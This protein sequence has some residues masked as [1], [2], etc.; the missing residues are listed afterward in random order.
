MT[1]EKNTIHRVYISFLSGMLLTC[2]CVGCGGQPGKATILRLRAGDKLVSSFQS[3]PASVF[4]IGHI[5][6]LQKDS[7]CFLE[8]LKAETAGELPLRSDSGWDAPAGGITLL[9][10][11]AAVA[12]RERLRGWSIMSLKDGND[13]ALVVWRP[14][15]SAKGV[16]D[17]FWRSEENTLKKGENIFSIDK[18]PE[19]IP[20]DFLGLATVGNIPRCVKDNGSEVSKK[21]YVPGFSKSIDIGKVP[22]DSSGSY[23]FATLSY[24]PILRRSF[25]LPAQTPVPVVFKLSGA[26]VVSRDYMAQFAVL[27]GEV[28][29]PVWADGR[30]YTLKPPESLPDRYGLYILCC[31]LIFSVALFTAARGRMAFL[32]GAA[33]FLLLTS[34]LFQNDISVVFKYCVFYGLFTSLPTLAI[35]SWLDK[36]KSEIPF[37]VMALG[38]YVTWK[39]FLMVTGKL[40]SLF[41]GSLPMYAGTIAMSLIVLAFKQRYVIP[42]FIRKVGSQWEVLSFSSR[43][44]FLSGLGLIL[45]AWSRGGLFQRHDFDSFGYV[46]LITKALSTGSLNSGIVDPFMGPPTAFMAAYILNPLIAF[47]SFSSFVSA[48]DPN[49]ILGFAGLENAFVWCFLAGGISWVIY[50][51]NNFLIA[52]TVLLAAIFQAAN[53]FFEIPYFVHYG[54]PGEAGFILVLCA[55]FFYLAYRSRKANELLLFSAFSLLTGLLCHIQFI[56]FAVM[57]FAISLGLSLVSYGKSRGYSTVEAAHWV[58]WLAIIGATYWLF[59]KEGVKPESFVMGTFYPYYYFNLLGH[60][61]VKPSVLLGLEGVAWVSTL[62]LTLAVL[63]CLW[64]RGKS[65]VASKFLA[66]AA[67]ILSIVYFMPGVP[68]FLVPRI[69][70]I[71]FIRLAFVWYALFSFFALAFAAFLADLFLRKTSVRISKV[72]MLLAGILFFCGSALGYVDISLLEERDYLKI[73]KIHELPVVQYLRTQHP[74]DLLICETTRA[75]WLGAQLPGYVY[76]IMPSRSRT[77]FPQAEIRFAENETIWKHLDSP[78]KIAERVKTLSPAV[79]LL[80]VDDDSIEKFYDDKYFKI[81]YFD[82]RWAIFGLR[83]YSGRPSAKNHGKLFGFGCEGMTGLQKRASLG[84]LKSPVPKG[85]SNK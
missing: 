62:G 85:G 43:L 36:N 39:A 11:A 73:D 42:K 54:N 51:G 65:T 13:A 82:G 52:L 76:S 64:D 3:I 33:L 28:A 35:A 60:K 47:Y 17:V 27:N 4:K 49:M 9:D 6:Q 1:I 46:A 70:E 23:C 14:R 81:L 58:S 7:R 40:F 5:T 8:I 84:H 20:G 12:R 38:G 78:A 71:A 68:E 66:A 30:F 57:Y 41:G 56:F 26:G 75:Y 55:V 16:Y 79:V 83:E 61:I 48:I 74:A 19:L 18:G 50:P 10:T 34:T 24:K 37:A 31:V 69:S 67:L 77:Y 80:S 59:P 53:K 72:Q 15:R 25:V 32:F 21:Y 29:L 2:F 22:N 63:V 45:L 44:F